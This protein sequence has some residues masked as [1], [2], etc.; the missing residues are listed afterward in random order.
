[1]QNV[2]T[3]FW[4]IVFLIAFAGPIVR[5]QGKDELSQLPYLKT[6]TQERLSSY[7]RTGGNDD[8]NWKNPIKSGETRTIGDVVGPGVITHMWFTRLELSQLK[9]DVSCAA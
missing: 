7:D 4:S 2:I 8:G 9:G 3:R 1:M 6:Y 5:A